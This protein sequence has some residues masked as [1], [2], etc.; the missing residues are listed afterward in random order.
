MELSWYVR[1]CH[2]FWTTE[3]EMTND[4]KTKSDS[5]PSINSLIRG[6]NTLTINSVTAKRKMIK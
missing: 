3:A 5:M 1:E 4:G 2:A 6:T